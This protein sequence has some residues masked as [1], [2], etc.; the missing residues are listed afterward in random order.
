MTDEEDWARFDRGVSKPTFDKIKEL[1]PGEWSQLIL[2][3]YINSLHN[4]RYQPSPTQQKRIFDY[5]VKQRKAEGKDILRVGGEPM[6]T[7][8]TESYFLFEEYKN[9]PKAFRRRHGIKK[10]SK[11]RFTKRGRARI[12][13]KNWKKWHFLEELAAWERGAET[14]KIKKAQKRIEAQSL[15]P[16]GEEIVGNLGDGI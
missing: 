10:G 12:K 5:I 9:A 15:N 13:A 16:A 2:A 11:I 1:H 14:R 7:K 4:L 6:P 8:L 3:D